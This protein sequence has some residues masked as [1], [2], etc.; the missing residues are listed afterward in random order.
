[1]TVATIFLLPPWYLCSPR[2]IPCQVPI[3]KLPSL[4]GILRDNLKN[5]DL[6]SKHTLTCQF[7]EIGIIFV[8][9]GL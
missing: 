5:D 9:I 1:M 8:E 6:I 4:I 2:Y 7:I 3:F